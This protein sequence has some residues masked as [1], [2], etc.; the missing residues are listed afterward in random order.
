M[1][2]VG[3][4]V[5][6]VPRRPVFQ[7]FKESHMTQFSLENGMR[8][9]KAQDGIIDRLRLASSLIDELESTNFSN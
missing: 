3:G 9:R 7:S 5:D 8:K 4:S 1:T 6:G 2:L